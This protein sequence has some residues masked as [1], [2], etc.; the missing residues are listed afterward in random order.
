[1]K[2][3]LYCFALILLMVCACTDESKDNLPPSTD[4]V[5]LAEDSDDFAPFDWDTLKGIYSGDFSG[6]DIRIKINYI[7]N[8]QVVGYNVHKGLLRNISGK[9][10]QTKDSIILLMQEPGDNPYDGTFK[11]MI[12]RK[13]LAVN[14]TWVPFHDNLSAKVFTLKKLEFDKDYNYDAKVTASNFSQFYGYVG[15]SLGDFAFFDD[16]LVEYTYYPLEDEVNRVEQMQEAKGSWT[17]NG[18]TVSINWQPNS[19]FPSLKSTFQVKKGEY[20]HILDGEGRTLYAEYG[21]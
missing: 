19:A 21:W 10:Q 3:L 6:S 15:D 8:K 17:L 20:G 12:D 16:G 13:T 1:M 5:A 11:L 7:S 18:S 9:V 2:T 4:E 14:G